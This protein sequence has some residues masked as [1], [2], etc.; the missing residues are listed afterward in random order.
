MGVAGPN[1]IAAQRGSG[2]ANA[3]RTALDVELHRQLRESVKG[4]Q[5]VRRGEAA[6]RLAA[7]LRLIAAD[8]TAKGLD[9]QFKTQLR[10]AIQREGEDSLLLKDIDG[11]TFAAEMKQLGLAKLPPRAGDYAARRRALRDI[12]SNGVTPGIAALADHLDLLSED[13]DTY[14]LVPVSMRAGCPDLRAQYAFVEISAMVACLSNA[15][16]C[17][18]FGG[19]YAGLRIAM[20]SQGC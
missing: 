13:F 7:T 8:F 15:I 3:G 11:T 2:G 5:G 18:V 6:R 14:P 9:A 4:L 16:L 10:V 20:T 17:A 1:L 12:L 19:M